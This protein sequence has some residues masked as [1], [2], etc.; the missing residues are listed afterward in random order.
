MRTP[1][2]PMLNLPPLPAI[3]SVLS[4]SNTRQARVGLRNMPELPRQGTDRG[5]D[6]DGDDED[7]DGDDEDDEEQ[8]QE[9]DN[10]TETLRDGSSSIYH[11]FDS[12]DEQNRRPVE[13]DAGIGLRPSLSSLRKPPSRSSSYSLDEYSGLPEV[14]TSRINIDLSFLNNPPASSSENSKGKGKARS[15]GQDNER[16]PTS[17]SVQHDYFSDRGM[18]GSWHERKDTSVTPTRTPR[19]GNTP[20]RMAFSPAASS[21]AF[22]LGSV[23]PRLLSEDS[24][25]PLSRR[26]S[27]NIDANVGHIRP[28][29]Y[30]HASHSMIDIHA[31]EKKEMVEEIVRDA[32]NEAVVEE[33]ARRRQSVM[34][35]GKVKG[36]GRESVIIPGNHNL[37]AGISVP[38]PP[39]PIVVVHDAEEEGEVAKPKRMSVAPA[40]EAGPHRLRRRRS[41]PS[42]IAISDPPPYPAFERNAHMYGL[43]AQLHIQPRDDEGRERLPPY[44]NDIYLKSIVPRKME[45]VA[46]GVQAKDRK[47]RRV[48]CVLEGTALK[49]YNC[50]ANVAGV[51]ALGGWWERKMGVGDVSVGGGA[52]GGRTSA[53]GSAAAR[54]TRVREE[55]EGVPKGGDDRRQT[56]LHV[57]VSSPPLQRPVRPQPSRSRLGLANLLRP[58]RTHTRSTSDMQTSP[59]PRSPR[60][61]LNIPVDAGG[62]VSSSRSH[63]PT[64]PSS[65]SILSASSH[66]SNSQSVL[67]APTTASSSRSH[68]RNSP[69]GNSNNGVGAKPDPDPNPAD[70]IR[71]YTMQHAESGL[72]NDYLK[73]KNVIRV[74]VEG[75]QFLFQAK[76]V[77]DVVTWIEVWIIFILPFRPWLTSFCGCGFPGT[78]GCR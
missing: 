56:E 34:V 4:S 62:S 21:S 5:D 49:V 65:A 18:E 50:P 30:N 12:L 1:P 39:S 14:N 32:E 45:F 70:L 51:S 41:M 33:K 57:P 22:V 8:E 47:W 24:L 29:M 59:R 76:D 11:G 78:A 58:G 72:G 35:S 23:S 44:S 68:F 20:V 38:P 2:L 15:S 25:G 55:E 74:R 9:Q 53:I 61:S 3:P 16:T 27:R 60:A 67:T 10:D 66:S 52:P 36:K 19:A 46:A 73:R 37:S 17:S 63:S 7:E 71:A 40:Y 43:P 69:R 31:A 64:T 13:S 48:V 28:G 77:A 26:L 6:G 42:F 54:E 75:E